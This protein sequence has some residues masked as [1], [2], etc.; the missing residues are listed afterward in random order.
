MADDD[1]GTAYDAVLDVAARHARA[2]LG[3]VQTRPVAASVG[4]D[5]I[6]ELLGGD[7]PPG[8]TPADQ[9]V[10]E[11]AT[12]AEPGLVAMGSGRFFGFVIGGTLPAALGADWLTS[13]WD[14]NAGMRTVTPAVSA[15][16]DIARRWL[17]QL[18]DLP[19]QCSVGWVT[20]ATMANFSALAAARYRVLERAGWNVERDGLQ[21]AP[22][23]R[24]L[25]GA[26]VHS[27]VEVALRMLGLGAPESVAVDDQG[28]MSPQALAEALAA[29]PPGGPLIVVLQAGNI[30]SGAF[31]EFAAL[32]PMA[33]E[34]GAWVHV[35]GAFGL[36]AAASPAL[37]PLAAGMSGADSWATDA[38][39]TLNVPYDSGVV[40]CA[41]ANAHRAA[42]GVH[43]PYL[44]QSDAGDPADFVPELSR[45]A[46]EFAIW[47]A[48]RSLGR[49]G[50]EDLMTGLC[51]AAARFA[52]GV[53][54]IPGTRVLNHVD[55]TQVCVGF[56]S[57]DLA[58]RVV[59]RVLADGTA[60]MSGS[61][62]HDQAILRVSVSNAW[63]SDADVD[64]SLAAL[65]RIVAEESHE[66][67]A[68]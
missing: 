8:P 65:A 53:G 22:R 17:L 24:V 60:W 14:Q 19:A 66:E 12:A 28:R 10:D 48:L 4:I 40:I 59:Q 30:H 36:W 57:D 62:W 27:S 26:E 37:Q 3:S 9:V 35:D 2:W 21:G 16:A 15:V 42:L 34:A 44:I 38:H 39:K 54:Q 31:D 55:Y 23:V 58:T 25:V 43:G 33:Q 45:R 5:A 13:T 41:D 63:T 6:A 7:L 47:A 52:D 18:L 29:T 46:R 51:R 32:V 1:N 61:R 49:A 56:E 64:R 50:V 11:L 67:S 20:G 68:S